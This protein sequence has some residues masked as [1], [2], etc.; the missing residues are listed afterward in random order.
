MTTAVEQC[1]LD[2]IRDLLGAGVEVNAQD[3][4]G[5]TALAYAAALKQRDAVD[6]LLDAGADPTLATNE[7]MTPLHMAVDPDVARTLLDAGADPNAR[8][9]YDQTPL[10][11]AALRGPAELIRTLIGRGAD[12]DATDSEGKTAVIYGVERGMKDNVAALIDAGAG[13]WAQDQSGLTAY[14]LARRK[15]AREIAELL[16]AAGAIRETT[17]QYFSAAA[18]GRI[19][20]VSRLLAAGLDV[21][22][23]FEPEPDFEMARCTSQREPAMLTWP[24]L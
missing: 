4:Q 2:A 5:T 11:F 15:N 16:Q 14:R 6:L 17:R 21:H 19:D 23:R 18:D 10:M 3:K 1:K 24:V 13:L 20:E 12:V 7:G 9:N 22:D 8:A